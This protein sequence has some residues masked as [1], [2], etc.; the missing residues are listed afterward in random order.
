MVLRF[1]QLNR[2]SSQTSPRRESGGGGRSVGL[3]GG[4]GAA[5][6]WSRAK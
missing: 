3:G 4:P 5:F 6:S 2:C 1:R